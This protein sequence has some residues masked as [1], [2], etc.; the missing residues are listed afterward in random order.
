[1]DFI[2]GKGKHMLFFS[3]GE[4]HLHP[5]AHLSYTFVKLLSNLLDV[6]S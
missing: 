2:E 6:A 3:L 1:V 5:F 4:L